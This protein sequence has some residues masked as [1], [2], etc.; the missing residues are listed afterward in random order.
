MGLA[1]RPVAPG[2]LLRLGDVFCLSASRP[3]GCP[4]PPPPPHFP[5]PSLC[6]ALAEAACC[7]WTHPRGCPSIAWAIGCFFCNMFATAPC[8]RGGHEARHFAVTVVAGAPRHYRPVRLRHLPRGW[9][10]QRGHPSRTAGT[11]WSE[12]TCHRA[13]GPQGCG[14]LIGLVT[15]SRPTLALYRFTHPQ[16][17]GG[18]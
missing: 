6:L 3:A 16:A 1:D 15:G 9:R 5:G 11:T 13:P 18:L 10:G 12:R 2:S 17:K 7:Y 4:V 8:A 14:W